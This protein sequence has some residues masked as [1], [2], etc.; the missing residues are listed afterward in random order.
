MNECCKTCRKYMELV[1]YDYGHGGCEH[2]DMGHACTV[3]IDEGR[4]VWMVGN[5]SEKDM[6]EAYMPRGKENAATDM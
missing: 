1:M 4:I 3:F 2:H 5:D 6:C